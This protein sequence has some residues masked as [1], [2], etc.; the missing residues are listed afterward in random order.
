MKIR[1]V[2]YVV[3]GA[4]LLLL[5]LHLAFNTDWMALIKSLHTPPKH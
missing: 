2:I 1:T 3:L 5:T 4:L